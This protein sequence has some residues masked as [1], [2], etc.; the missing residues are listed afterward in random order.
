M[1]RTE[2]AV[3]VETIVEVSQQRAFDVFVDM[4]AWWP[5]SHHTGENP[6][7]AIVLQEQPPKRWFERDE[8]G[9]EADWGRVL[10]Y[11]PSSN[12]LLDWQLNTEFTYD[13][14]LHTDLEVRFERLG[15]ARTRVDLVHRLDGYGD[16]AAKMLEIFAQPGA[17]QGVLDAYGAVA[18][19]G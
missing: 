2:T 12:L 17:W 19:R 8:H 11:Q 10:R 14:S 7:V 16:Q 15:D 5:A 18:S 9:A 4:A 13:P 1:N 3:R 6:W